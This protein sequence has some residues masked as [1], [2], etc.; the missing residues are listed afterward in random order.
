MEA[1][2]VKCEEIK[3]IVCTVDGKP[4]CENCFDKAMVWEDEHVTKCC[5]TCAWYEDFQGV[6]FNGDSTHCA[7]FTEPE[8]ACEEWRKKD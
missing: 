6:C 7:D 4:W 2:C 1:K 5:A 8:D 3:E